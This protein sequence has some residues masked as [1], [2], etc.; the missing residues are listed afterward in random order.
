MGTAGS[1][2]GHFRQTLKHG[3]WQMVKDSARDKAGRNVKQVQERLGH[4]DPSFTL[5]T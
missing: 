2:Y 4:A 3:S 5:R 1:P